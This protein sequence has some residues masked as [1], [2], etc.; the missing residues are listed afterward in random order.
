MD[1]A[2]YAD[3]Q[4]KKREVLET[5]NYK[6]FGKPPSLFDPAN[7]DLEATALRLSDALSSHNSVRTGAKQFSMPFHP[8]AIGNEHATKFLKRG[9][10][11]TRDF[12]PGGY[13]QETTSTTKDKRRETVCASCGKPGGNELKTCSGCRQIF[14]CSP[15]HQKEHWKASHKEQCSRKYLKKN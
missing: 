13:W 15:E 6:D 3:K 8:D 9:Q 5:P 7:F 2:S 4:K 11:I 12:Q 1:K 14:Y 10:K